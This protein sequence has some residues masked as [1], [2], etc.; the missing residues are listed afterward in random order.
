MW[1]L[2]FDLIYFVGSK[3][4]HCP[5]ALSYKSK[6]QRLV[7]QGSEVKG[8]MGHYLPLNWWIITASCSSLNEHK[9]ICTS[10]HIWNPSLD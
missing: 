1:S 6:G 4:V 10:T 3:D 9:G 5:S 2:F 8:Q 7:G